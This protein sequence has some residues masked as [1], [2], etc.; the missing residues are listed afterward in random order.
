MKVL[1]CDPI[2]Q[3]GID[4]LRQEAQVDVRLGLG[5]QELIAII[6]EYDALVVRSETKVAAPILEAGKRLKV[7]ARAG[8]GVD[9]IDVDVATRLGIV[10][11]NAPAGSTVAAAEHT[12]A[13]ML[14]LARHV[15]QAYTS[16]R[17]G[18]WRRAQFVGIELKG[19]TLGIIGLGRIGAEVAKRALG[20]EMEV[21]ACDPYISPEKA[22]ALGVRLVDLE[23]LLQT[24]DFISLHVPLTAATR[25]LLG[26]KELAKVKAGACILNVARGGIVDEAALVAAIQEGRV[27]GAAV[28]V[29]DQEP[30]PGDS[31][32]LT[33]DRI[34]VTP[35]LGASTEEAQRKVAQDI[36]EQILDLFHGRPAKYAVNAP[37][38]LPE[39][40]AVLS[41]YM[42]VADRLGRY[43]TQ[44]ED[45][46]M[47][48]IEITYA[49]ALVEH[50]T[51]A[52]RAALLR[53]LLE[54]I[55]EATVNLINAGVIAAERGIRVVE[56]ADLPDE[57]FGNL[58]TLR[59]GE[60]SL[61]GAFL[62]GEPHIVR[63]DNIPVDLEP[64][65]Y[66]L[67]ARC[68][69]HPGLLGQIG[70]LLGQAGVNISSALFSRPGVDGTSV[71]ILSLDEPVS[72]EVC[73]RIE[74]I[75][76]VQRVRLAQF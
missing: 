30:L 47:D 59:I 50:D 55:C 15:P 64:K 45:G 16:L 12:I 17:Q 20:L 48:L 43:F 56:H 54:P 31:L 46:I 39:A 68:I 42:V 52:L 5:P 75:S 74:R 60:R 71:A 33:C 41:P 70:M 9:N 51:A 66:L 23:S 8:V 11:I 4:L 38:L 61:S 53:G 69:D 73:R 21:I 32:L 65:G 19:K 35:H 36:A 26:P 10:V 7:V 14:A 28:D 27:A 37:V 24:A 40:Q 6:P 34:I 2:A 22:A 76:G 58:I 49:G 72:E 1:I 25:G 29:F 63:I 44:V 67:V 18:Q 62:H 57:T 3:E 13:L